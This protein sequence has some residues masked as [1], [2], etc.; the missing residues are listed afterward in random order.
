[1]S[2]IG[3]PTGNPG[4]DEA[5]ASSLQGLQPG[6]EPDAGGVG[7]RVKVSSDYRGEAIGVGIAVDVIGDG[8]GLHLAFQFHVGFEVRL[9]IHQQYPSHRCRDLDLGC[10]DGAREFLATTRAGQL[11]QVRSDDREATGNGRAVWSVGFLQVKLM[12]G[13]VGK[14]VEN[15]PGLVPGVTVPQC[16]LERDDVRVESLDF[17][18]DQSITGR[19]GAVDVEV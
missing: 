6:Q 14:T 15:L 11:H 9:G 5:S 12:D 10:L 7:C 16:F 1:M 19:V 3:V 4:I 8:D 2:R 17:V 13:F 18:V